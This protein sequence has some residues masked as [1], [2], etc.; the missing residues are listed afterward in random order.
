MLTNTETKVKFVIVSWR[1]L[2]SVSINDPLL[3]LG[4]PAPLTAATG[5]DALTHAVEAYISRCPAGH[6]R[7][8]YSGYSPDRTQLASGRSA[9]Q[10]PESSREHG[11]RLPAGR[12][13]LQQHRQS[14]L[15]S[16]WRMQ[17]AVCTTCRTAWRMPYCCRTVAR[18]NLIA[19]PEK[20][21][22]IAEFMG[23]N[24][25]GFHGCRRT[26]HSRHCSS[27]C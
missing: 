5:M 24:T 12:Y 20:F 23:E 11:L 26:G 3:M 4:K 16:R 17:Q 22:D 7:C 25:D 9:G 2:P 8:R 13:G 14:R 21:A 10:Q 6:R 27:L 19:N 1:N 18:Y 15:R